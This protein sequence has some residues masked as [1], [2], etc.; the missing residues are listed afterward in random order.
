M[1]GMKNSF[2]NS[3][4]RC[5][6]PET[7]KMWIHGC[8]TGWLKTLTTKHQLL[9]CFV[10]CLSVRPL[11]VLVACK[12]NLSL[13]ITICKCWWSLWSQVRPHEQNSLWRNCC[14]CLGLSIAFWRRHWV[15]SRA[16]LKWRRSRWHHEESAFQYHSWHSHQLPWF[17][18]EDSG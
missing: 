10:L 15:L 5:T 16:R 13:P 2:F 12:M 1:I 9:N 8:W 3:M 11:K 6:S 14:M 4:Q 7:L 18:H 17:L